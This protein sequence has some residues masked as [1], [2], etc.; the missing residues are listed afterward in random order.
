VGVDALTVI[1]PTACSRQ[2]LAIVHH[3]V[4]GIT[5]LHFSAVPPIYHHD[6]KLSNILLDKQLDGKVTDFRLPWTR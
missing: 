3:T 4:E 1:S 5:Y 2:R 6:I